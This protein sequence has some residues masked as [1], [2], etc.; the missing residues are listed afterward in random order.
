MVGKDNVWTQV[1]KMFGNRK[2][3]EFNFDQMEELFSVS[4]TD[5]NK[6]KD[7]ISGELNGGNE[8]KKKSDEVRDE[9]IIRY[10]FNSMALRYEFA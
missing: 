8:K 4:N 3:Y 9:N 5:N 6:S 10:D 7:M 2:S 1:G